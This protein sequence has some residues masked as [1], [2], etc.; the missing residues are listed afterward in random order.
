MVGRIQLIKSVIN[1]MLLLTMKIYSWPISLIKDIEKWI[2]KFIWSGDITKRKMLTVAWKRV[3]SDYDEGGL[4]IKSLICLNEATNLKLCWELLH[5]EEQWANLLRSRTLRG[6]HY[7]NH[8][9]FSSIW[10]GI[11]HEYSTIREISNLVMV[12]K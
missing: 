2:K 11:K 9:I 1:S 4:G 10:S 12:F 8:P 6:N 5:S 3:C 7:I